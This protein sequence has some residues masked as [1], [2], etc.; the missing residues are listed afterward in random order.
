M[1][2]FYSEKMACL[3]NDRLK[4]Q[5]NQWIRTSHKPVWYCKMPF[6]S[7]ILFFSWCT[8]ASVLRII[9]V[10]R[11]CW[12]QDE[13]LAVGWVWWTHQ[14]NQCKSGR[15][16]LLVLS[17]PSFTKCWDAES[18][19]ISVSKNVIMSQA[20]IILQWGI[21]ENPNQSIWG[22]YGWLN[23]RRSTWWMVHPERA[24]SYSAHPG[25]TLCIFASASF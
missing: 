23:A 19:V 14:K 8:T 10:L 7:F 15:S 22:V 6:W 21:H 9:K 3:W 4:V 17:P 13:M 24:Q 25:P 12:N 11:S 20:A 5:T 1:K 2:S 16:G 18:S